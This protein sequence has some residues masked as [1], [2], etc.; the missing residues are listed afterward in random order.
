RRP[1]ANAHLNYARPSWNCSAPES[2][3]CRRTLTRN[4]TLPIAQSFRREVIPKLQPQR[5]EIRSAS[6]G[7]FGCSLDQQF[8]G[9]SK[10]W[11][12]DGLITRARR[13]RPL[14][15][16]GRWLMPKVQFVLFST[17]KV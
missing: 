15:K 4:F 6:A 7:L 5:L 3:L 10:N 8:E 9:K 13:T 11:A 12:P 17:E 16:L 1:F 14:E 2:Y